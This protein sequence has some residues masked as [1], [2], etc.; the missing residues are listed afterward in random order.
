MTDPLGQLRQ[1]FTGLSVREA[2]PQGQV[3]VGHDATGV[4]VTIAVLAAPLAAQPTIRNTFADVVWRH[5]VGSEPGRAT[6]YAADL[7]AALP[8]A[9]VRGRAGHP[10]AEQ[11]LS[12]LANTAP[13]TAMPASPLPPPP[14]PLSAV[15]QTPAPPFQVLYQ[16]Q[17]PM[18]P[19]TGSRPL[20][21]VLGGAALI[22]VLV[23]AAAVIAVVALRG[24]EPGPPQTLPTT[25]P[26]PPA[27][28]S[29]AP[30]PTGAPTE[31]P[32]EEPLGEPELRDVELVSVVG[33][34]FD[35]GDDTF[36][37]AFNGWPFAFR[38][39]G[40]WNCLRGDPIPLFPGAEIWGC[41]GGSGSGHRANVM[42]WECEGGCDD[43]EQQEKLETWLDE[44][45]RA[46]QWEDSPTYYVETEEDDEAG[47]YNVDLGHFFGTEAD[48]LRWM[49]GV[50]VESPP[51]T[52]EAVQKTLN[53][54]IS[55]AG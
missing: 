8:W 9:A 26:A 12:A 35:P 5:S 31:E 51:D 17:L 27:T 14:P 11:L 23:A 21:W 22:V 38:T 43:A 28:G 25:Q 37:M 7:H 3:F 41:V 54:I 40:D 29:P 4:E 16:D 18:P 24:D 48:D 47:L 10:G 42:L 39:P 36:T 44:P 34:N 52:R 20:P 50:Y 53:D 49:V 19:A 46:V 1:H 2:G 33:P 13:T 15:P 30:E 6:V 45:D 55:Q 32:T